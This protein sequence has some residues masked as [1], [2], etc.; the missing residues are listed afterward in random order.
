MTVGNHTMPAELLRDCTEGTFWCI[1][2]WANNV[3]QGMF[4]LLVLLAFTIVIY[5]STYRLGTNRAFGFGSFV[6]MIGAIWFAIMGLLD[7]SIATAFILVG[8]VGIVGM[9]MSER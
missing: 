8:V 5:M 9:I 3:T 6:G 4:W 7:W 2:D 1:S